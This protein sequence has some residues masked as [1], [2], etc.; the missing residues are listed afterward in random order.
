MIILKRFCKIFR[1]RGDI[2]VYLKL[3]GVLHTGSDETKTVIET[4]PYAGHRGVKLGGM[5]DA[6]ESNSAVRRTPG[7]ET[8]RCAGHP[9]V[10]LGDSQD[11]GE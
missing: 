11:T 3:P 1:I 5:Q 8:W 10:K 6:G 7:R 9:G 2:R 4:R